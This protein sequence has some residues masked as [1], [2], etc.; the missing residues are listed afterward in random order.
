MSRSFALATSA[1]LVFAMGSAAA[2]GQSGGAADSG[3]EEVVVTAERRTENLQKVPVTVTAVSEEQLADSGVTNIQQLQ[4]LVPSL[5]VVDPT[6]YNMAFIRGIGSSTL[7]GGTFS[8]VAIYIDGVY[9]ARTTNAMFELDSVAGL[10]VLAG[11]QGSLYGRNATAGAI[12]INSR[13]PEPGAEFSGNVSA[14]IGNYNTRDISASISS[15]L[16]ERTAFSLSAAK[17][18]RDGFVKNLNPAGSLN[19][20]D[21][22]DR[23]AM[24][25]SAVFVF[26]PSDTQSWFL[27][28]AYSK[29]DDHSGGGYE[30]VGQNVPG[31][32]PGFSDN[33][34]VFFAAIFGG[35]CPDPTSPTAC[36]FGAATTQQIA[37]EAATSAVFSNRI[38]ET[39]D[40]QRSGFTNGVLTGQHTPGSSLYIENT[41]VVLNGTFD[42][43]RFTLK[44][45]TGYTDSDYHGSVQVGLERPGSVQSA[46]LGA[47]LG[48]GG[49]VPLNATGGLGFSSINPSE[50][51]S[52][53][54]Q[55]ISNESAKIRWIGGIDYSREKGQVVQSGDGFGASSIGTDD[56]FIVTSKAAYA[57]ATF[58]FGTN[59]SATVGGRITDESYD[60]VDFTGQVPREV[61]DGNK[62][63]Y[64]ARVQYQADEWLAYG[65]VSTGFKSGT[66]NA[67]T[68]GAGSAEPEEVTTIEVGFKRDFADRYRLNASLYFSEYEN[69]Q[70][71]IIDQFTGGNILDNGPKAEVKGVDLQAIAKVTDNFQLSLG[72]TILNAEFTENSVNL[73]TIKGNSLPGAS[74]LAISLVGDYSYPLANG[75]SIDFT[76]TV[77]HNGG[78]YYDHLNLVGSGGATDDGYSLLNLNIGYKAP[79]DRWSISLWGNNVL[80]EEYYRTGIIAF[81]TFGRAAIAGNPANYGATVKFNF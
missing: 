15:G 41:L 52:Q 71:N 8:S 20:D 45:L 78:K 7:G 3:L 21:L 47:I 22:D 60:L 4:S 65:G 61:L 72:A 18:D 25:A 12:V 55:F 32:I 34:S 48:A 40:N 76:G 38:H 31:P 80:D 9:I 30:A 37:A 26:N 23:E 5:S 58:P 19:T 64:T 57:Q 69:V 35:F 16:G 1:V 27:R 68:T 46:T 10:E 49:P 36:A 28:A 81:G 59:W 17:H 11:P 75:G 62:F 2:Q 53:G 33:R 50:V 66:L 13:K 29:S 24:S 67:A 39:Y 43:D 56:E 70:L 79:D 6:G 74:D 73:P 14:S 54:F 42:F 77:V 44:S 51:I 63:T